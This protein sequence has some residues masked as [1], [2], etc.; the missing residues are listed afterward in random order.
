M[1][2]TLEENVKIRSQKNRYYI[3][4]LVIVIVIIQKNHYFNLGMKPNKTEEVN[5]NVILEKI[6]NKKINNK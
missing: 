4:V 3:I 1:I 5:C 2:N 6:I